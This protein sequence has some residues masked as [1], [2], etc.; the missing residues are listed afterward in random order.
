[1]TAELKWFQMESDAPNSRS[2]K[3]IRSDHGLEGVAIVFY[4]WCFIAR[5]GHGEPGEGVDEFGRAYSLWD[6][7]S[8]IDITEEELVNVINTCANVGMV[9]PERLKEGLVFLP[10]MG[11]RASNYAKRKRTK[12]KETVQQD[13][14]TYN[15]QVQGNSLLDVES[16]SNKRSVKSSGKI[17]QEF[18]NDARVG[19]IPT[20]VRSSPDRI[21]KANVLLDIYSLKE[22][23]SALVQMNASK[24]CQGDNDRD[25][26]P[27]PK[28]FL[29]PDSPA[30]VL[31][32]KYDERKKFIKP[33]HAVSEPG[34]FEAFA[35]ETGIK[36]HNKRRAEQ[37]KQ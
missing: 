24:F 31:E 13:S 5:E 37:W 20:W 28:W 16:T 7:A 27:D 34:A 8:D 2:I 11:D 17:L 12:E 32:G 18:W 36:E 1:M 22:L 4:L 9:D 6:I 3:R 15:V 10:A 26:K 30:Q 21:K 14:T 33:G 23:Q 25:W 35:T 19:N 29:K